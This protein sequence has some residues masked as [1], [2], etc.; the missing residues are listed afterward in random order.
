MSVDT[1]RAE[2]I[3]VAMGWQPADYYIEGARVINVFTGELLDN[4]GI[5][6]KGA[7][8]AY[9]GSNRDMVSS[10]TKI[11]A[12]AGKIAVPGYI[13]AHA[14]IDIYTNPVAFAESV[15]P[16]GTTTVLTATLD[17]GSALGF[18]CIQGFL[19][20]TEE[21]PVKVYIGLPTESLEAYMA[22][23]LHYLVTPG[24]YQK[25][26]SSN[27]V[28]SLAEIANWK[29]IIDKQVLEIFETMHQGHKRIDGHT[30]GA[31]DRE[32][33]ALGAAGVSSCHEAFN[34]EQALERIRLGFS[35]MLR[36][37][38]VRKDLPKL[39][40]GLLNYP[41]LNWAK[42]MLTPDFM[43]PNDLVDLG[44][45]DYLVQEALN[46]GCP[47]VKAYQMS[48]L[49][50]AMYLGLEGEIGSIA[51][52]KIAD[53]LLLKD[54]E[55]P[56][57]EWVM[58]NGIPVAAKGE[59]LEPMIPISERI[60]NAF[61]LKRDFFPDL[62]LNKNSFSIKKTEKY[63]TDGG[64]L[65]VPV[66]RIKTNTVTDI[67]WTNVPV[68]KDELILPFQGELQKLSVL[69]KNR[70]S[71]IT[72]FMTGTGL[73][74]GAIAATV[75]IGRNKL[76]ILGSSEDAM[77]MA[78]NRL[79]EIGGGIVVYARGQVQA[80]CPMVIGGIAS[81][82][83][84]RELAVEFRSIYQACRDLGCRLEDPILTLHFLT[85]KLPFVRPTPLGL[86]VTKREEIIFP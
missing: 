75:G 68:D 26:L 50:A 7:R 47:P 44:Y 37:G 45:M 35:V 10:Q 25:L 69:S 53:I 80:E 4:T 1:K 78:G 58:A 40:P 67:M 29:L 34:T 31:K 82:R 42:I 13:D 19:E 27:R 63:Q 65:R 77:V 48:T 30:N 76:I 61:G 55:T 74:T 24:A 3:D 20:L 32:L 52:G 28:L 2:L 12:A 84:V 8:I 41:N 18:D 73:T 83:S 86:M 54:L 21:L 62:P 70:D 46:C 51:P 64:Q 81:S 56:R 38:S 39:L 79:Y 22:D 5:A 43:N 72:C 17:W 66:L 15:I 6:I 85:S 16:L 11:I 33:N 71:L 49:N 59:L 9:V 14:H 36:N 23:S 60:G 57:P